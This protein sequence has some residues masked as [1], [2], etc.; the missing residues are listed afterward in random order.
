L[1]FKITVVLWR[2]YDGDREAAAARTWARALLAALAGVAAGLLF[3]PPG[4]GALFWIYTGLAGA[5]WQAAHA[6][7]PQL[8]AVLIRR[9]RE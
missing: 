3:S 2:R 8:G 9:S 4:H 5:L 1:S 7:D 6:H